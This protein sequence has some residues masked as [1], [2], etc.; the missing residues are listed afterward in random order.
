[1]QIGWYNVDPTT[2][3]YSKLFWLKESLNYQI[4]NEIPILYSVA[5]KLLCLTLLELVCLN[6][7]MNGRQRGF[8]YEFIYF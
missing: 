2:L 7:K 6:K 4:V 8:V 1:M 3:I 5:L